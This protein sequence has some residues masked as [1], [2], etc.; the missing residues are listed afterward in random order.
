MR[1]LVHVCPSP[2]P[3]PKL[4]P[5]LSRINC[6]LQLYRLWFNPT[7]ISIGFPESKKIFYFEKWV[8]D[9]VPTWVPIG[10]PLE[11]PKE[12]AKEKNI[13]KW[14]RAKCAYCLPRRGNNLR[15]GSEKGTR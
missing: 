14:N 12:P 9:R 8:P 1:G 4:N 7:W 10:Y 6:K 11:G 2:Y 13:T 5:K 15:S 3:L